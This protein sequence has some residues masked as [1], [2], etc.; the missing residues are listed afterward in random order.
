[1]DKPAQAIVTAYFKGQ[2]ALASDVAHL[3]PTDIANL[4]AHGITSLAV[5]DHLVNLTA[6]QTSALGSGGISLIE[7]LGSGSQ[8]WTWNPDGSVHDVQYYA[9]RTDGPPVLAAA[10]TGGEPQSLVYD[11]ASVD[12][13]SADRPAM[14]NGWDFLRGLSDSLAAFA[15][16]TAAELISAPL[17]SAPEDARAP[18][19]DS[20]SDLRASLVGA[21]QAANNLVFTHRAGDIFALPDAPLAPPILHDIR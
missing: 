20:C 8:T 12:P 4:A 3:S 7:P 1:M 15:S 2:G 21:V 9:L 11:G 16:P 13:R 18:A 19:L 17:P 6:A 10:T 5:T 14:S